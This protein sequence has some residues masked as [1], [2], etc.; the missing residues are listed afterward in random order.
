M[1]HRIIILNQSYYVGML[2]FSFRV[3]FMLQRGPV[4]CGDGVQPVQPGVL[5][6]S[7]A[8]KAELYP[9]F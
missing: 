3:L 1:A 8:T 9:G 5:S 4:Y 2:A 7:G 6:G